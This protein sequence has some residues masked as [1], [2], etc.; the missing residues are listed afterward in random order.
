MYHVINNKLWNI[1]ALSYN[2]PP[3]IS[4]LVT[5]T[6]IPFSDNTNNTFFWKE[7]ED[8][9]FSR[10]STS[11]L[12]IKLIETNPNINNYNHNW[13]WKA[14]CHN[15]LKIFLWL[16]VH[17]RLST[18]TI[19]NQKK[20]IDSSNCPHCGI[21]ENINHISFQWTMPYREFYTLAHHLLIN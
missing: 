1:D 5:Q 16:L 13:I 21:E 8:G 17:Q 18:A 11:N 19:L 10:K 20:I 3:T 14:H 15:K 9:N 12:F 7:T 4:D 6:Y 2:L